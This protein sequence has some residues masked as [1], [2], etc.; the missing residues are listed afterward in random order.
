MG[1]AVVAVAAGVGGER[2]VVEARIEVVV[3]DAV[4]V[5]GAAV[6]TMLVE[7]GG[8]MV[9]AEEAEVVDSATPPLVPAS[10]CG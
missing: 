6:D 4:V 5:D 3:E 1:D 2:V 7:M 9:S 8:V 10:S